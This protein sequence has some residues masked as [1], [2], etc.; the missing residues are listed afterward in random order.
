MKSPLDLNW[1]FHALHYFG[2]TF[3]SLSNLVKKEGIIS[4]PN[5]IHQLYLLKTETHIFTNEDIKLCP[6]NYD[7]GRAGDDLRIF[8]KFSHKIGNDKSIILEWTEVFTGTSISTRNIEDYV[9]RSI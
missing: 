5:E 8:W 7:V 6:K 2:F 9:K 1:I 3:Q 4:T